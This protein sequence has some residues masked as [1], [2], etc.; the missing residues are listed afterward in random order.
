MNK[1]T[2]LL[3]ISGETLDTIM[4]HVVKGRQYSAYRVHIR[5]LSHRDA[6]RESMVHAIPGTMYMYVHL[7]GSCGKPLI[8]VF[9]RSDA[10]LE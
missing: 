3:K 1:N 6:D 7:V 4:M 2:A 8:T 10:A 9:P 5:C